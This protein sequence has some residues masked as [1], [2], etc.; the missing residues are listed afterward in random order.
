[1]IFEMFGDPPGWLSEL[2]RQKGRV[3]I[4]FQELGELVK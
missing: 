4:S 2:V 3:R 1:M